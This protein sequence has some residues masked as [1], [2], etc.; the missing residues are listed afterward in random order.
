M[1]YYL[2]KDSD[3]MKKLLIICSIFMM[4]FSFNIPKIEAKTLGD[5]KRELAEM[6]RKKAEADEKKKLTQNEMNTINDRIDTI[7]NLIN[8]SEDKIREL[9]DE[10]EVLEEKSNEKNDEIKDVIAFLQVTDS[11][12]AYLEYIFGAQSITDLIFRTAISE[13]LVEYNNDLIDEYNQTVKEHTE[14]KEELDIE[15]Q[16]LDSEQENLRGE[17]VKL[18]D[19]LNGMVEIMVDIGD[20]IKTQRS[21]IEKYEEIGCTDN[22][23]ISTCG[24]IP[25]AGKFIRP[26]VTGRITSSFG[27]RNNP[28]ASGKSFHNGIDLSGGQTAVYAPAPGTVAGIT[29]KASCGGNMLYIHHNINGVHYTTSY[30]HLAKVLVSIG[31]YV[32]QNTQIGVMGGNKSTTPWDRCSTGT[33]LHFSIARGLYLREYSSWNTYIAKQVNPVSLINF[34]AKGVWISNR[35]KTY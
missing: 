13:Q 32:D 4:L 10:I 33:H 17:L 11:N 29:W 8:K 26:I 23:D 24:S 6:E 7:T 28:L 2:Y 12:N 22:Q 14:K 9:T 15:I 27:W 16:N 21:V 34:P 18:G 19:E 20:E 1:L 3:G 25:Y 30:F 5:L 31:D 35:T